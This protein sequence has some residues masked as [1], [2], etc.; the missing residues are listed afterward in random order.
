MH[1][2]SLSDVAVAQFHRNGFLAPLRACGPS[3]MAEYRRHFEALLE[4]DADRHRPDH[5]RHLDDFVVWSVCSLP[6]LV[7]AARSVLGPDLLLWRSNFFN[8]EPGG[9][10]VPWHQDGHFWPIEPRV[11]LT[12]WVA[13]DHVDTGNSCVQVVPETHRRW[14]VHREAADDMWLGEEATPT[15]EELRSLVDIELEPG[16]FFL[17]NERT[18]HHSE[19]NRSERRR[20]GLSVRMTIPQVR[21]MRYD[22]SEHRLVQLSGI[23]PLGFN[24]LAEPPST[25]TA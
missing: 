23:D 2:G 15:S 17:F 5:N 4:R 1:D 18:L 9:K 10:E 3:E 12:A 21:V 7:A 16:E 24:R 6:R 14:F 22:G 20:M 13:V 19:P 8:K 11:A 25:T